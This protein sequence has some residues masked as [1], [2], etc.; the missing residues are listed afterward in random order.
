MGIFNFNQFSKINEKVGI[1]EA[2]ILYT[3]VVFDKVWNT[4]REFHT[5]GEG[6]LEEKIEIPYR[7]FYKKIKDR[8]L[9]SKFPV[10]DILL[11]VN[12]TKLP[13]DT[14]NG[15][16]TSAASNRKKHVVG[17]W[18]SRFG[19]K[20]WEGY[21]T[22]KQ[23]IKTITDHG[24]SV[25]I[26]VDVI[27]SKDFN[28]GTYWKKL[29]D[30]INECIWHE[31]NH[32]YEYYQRLISGN[33]PLWKRSPR[34][35]VTFADD[36]RWRIS[37][38]IHKYWSNNFTY[39]LYSSEPYELNAQ[40]QE[41]G[42]FVKRYGI[43]SLKDTSAWQY[44]TSMENFNADEFI[45]GLEEVIR[46][47]GK[48]VKSTK[49]NLKKMWLGEYRKFLKEND[50]DPTINDKLVERLDCEG[51]VKLMAKRL[52]KAGRKLKIKLGKLYAFD[53]TSESKI[54]VEKYIFYS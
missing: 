39:Y 46:D 35:A 26:G 29:V 54:D 6:F 28:I 20:N 5:S 7:E 14:F 27:V 48:D 33:G 45:K 10:V 23:P 37:S 13:T 32:S 2:T 22:I 25:S 17:G 47:D 11:F 52:N 12:F 3:D 21:S 31:L 40:V 4:F 51:F 16:Y 49:E 41:A 36:N 44:A 43:D 1:A 50:E 9:Y 38:K 8:D 19:H 30:D 24:I 15:K 34:L 53:K 18:S 42:Y